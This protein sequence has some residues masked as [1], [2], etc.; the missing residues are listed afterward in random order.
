M[1]DRN[2]YLPKEG[3]LAVSP[4]SIWIRR[5]DRWLE[6]RPLSELNKLD[7]ACKYHADN[8]SKMGRELEQAQLN[9]AKA[10]DEIERLRARLADYEDGYRTAMAEECSESDDRKHCTCVP[11]LRRGIG[12]LRARLAGVIGYCAQEGH[13]GEPYDTI[14]A[15][16]V[17]EF[18]PCG[19]RQADQP[20]VCDECGGTG[21]V[22]LQGVMVGGIEG[23]ADDQ[24]CP[25]CSQGA[26]NAR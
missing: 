15:I 12:E 26:S 19:S 13:D 2:V 7:A 5:E 22:M 25:F 20:S 9:L 3:D 17:G 14:N 8:A 16:A 4:S 21:L 1:N 11:D 23:D 24:P 18:D 6:Y 10:A